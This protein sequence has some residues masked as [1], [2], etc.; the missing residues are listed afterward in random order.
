MHISFTRCNTLSMFPLATCCYTV[1]VF[2]YGYITLF[3]SKYAA[4]R[5]STLHTLTKMRP[6]HKVC[7]ICHCALLLHWLSVAFWRRW[8]R[9]LEYATNA[10]FFLFVL[11]YLATVIHLGHETGLFF[12][13][14]R[15]Y[16]F[17]RLSQYLPT[18]IPRAF[19]VQLN[20]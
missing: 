14:G 10:T 13:L 6:E 1:T 5:Y 19:Q 18:N 8:N 9:I 7:C 17:K 2:W 3:P 12:L 20:W 15:V 11:Y 16:L 4:M